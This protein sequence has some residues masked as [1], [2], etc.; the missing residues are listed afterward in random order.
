M[1]FLLGYLLYSWKS[2]FSEFLKRIRIAIPFGL[3]FLILIKVLGFENRVMVAG[4]F[5][6][7]LLLLK[8]SN[9]K[10]HF[11][12][13]LIP[14]SIFIILT[15]FLLIPI[16]DPGNPHEIGYLGEFLCYISIMPVVSFFLL[17]M[18]KVEESETPDIKAILVRSVKFGIAICILLEATTFIGIRREISLPTGLIANSLLSILFLVFCYKYDLFLIERKKD[19]KTKPNNI[20]ECCGKTGL[21]QELLFK[22]DSGQ[23]VCAACLAKMDDKQ[24][25]ETGDSHLIL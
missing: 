1:L 7:L 16:L 24:E 15:K 14:A 4:L 25:T 13:V 23:R 8:T 12:A 22:I 21:S 19:S 11:W 18:S 20:C 17:Y 10:T 6:C 2:N 9:W 3:A 5:I